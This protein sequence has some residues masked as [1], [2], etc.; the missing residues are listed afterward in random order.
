M[1]S[2]SRLDTSNQNEMDTSPGFDAEAAHALMSLQSPTIP[3]ETFRS[4]SEDTI[5]PIPNDPEKRRE[6]H[7]NL[8]HDTYGGYRPKS[9]EALVIMA[10]IHH[11]RRPA[12]TVEML[13][14]LGF[15]GADLSDAACVAREMVVFRA[16]F[17]VQHK[18]VQSVL[19]N[20]AAVL[21]QARELLARGNTDHLSSVPKWSDMEP[22]T[23]RENFV[24]LMKDLET[25]SNWAY[26]LNDAMKVRG[27]L[28]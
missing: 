13:E 21:D 22:A 16:S 20:P 26:A 14:D 1:A 9:G 3:R 4:P 24:K 10:T 15:N 19:E 17:F 12:P 2:S 8:A 25:S 6:Y 28:G 7:Q 11:H 27:V 5:R 23:A 18:D